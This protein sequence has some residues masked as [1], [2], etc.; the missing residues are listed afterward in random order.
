MTERIDGP[1][2]FVVGAPKAGTDWTI[3]GSTIVVVI[4]FALLL[5]R[6]FRFFKLLPIL[7]AIVFAM[8]GDP[9]LGPLVHVAGAN[10]DLQRLAVPSDHRRV[11]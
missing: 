7:S 6:R 3:G 11:Q 10:L 9:V 5:S 1:D 4:V 8:G 2:F